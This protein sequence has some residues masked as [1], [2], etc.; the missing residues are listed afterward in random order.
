LVGNVNDC[1]RLEAVIAAIPRVGGKRGHPV[2]G[3]EN[4]TQTKAMMHAKCR[5]A[6]RRRGITPRIARRGVESKE[7]LGLCR[8]PS[9]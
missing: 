7:R 3:R 8:G 2:D 6:L 1:E 9:N 4:F 5:R